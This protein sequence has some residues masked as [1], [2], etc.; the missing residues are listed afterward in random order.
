VAAIAVALLL[1]EQ[2]L[3]F[4]VGAVAVWRS[5]Q[6]D[7]GPGDMRTLATFVMLIIALAW[8]ARGVG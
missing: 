8:L 6:R 7:A 3:L 5:F 2:R 1:T 4:V